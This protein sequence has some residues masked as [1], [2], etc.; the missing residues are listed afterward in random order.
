MSNALYIFIA[1]TP[2][3]AY[4]CWSEWTHH[5]LPNTWTMGMLAVALVWRWGYGGWHLLV[6][7][8]LAG[9]LGGLVLL[10]PFLLKAAGG[11]D[12]KMLTA[13][14]CVLGTRRLL[15]MLFIMSWLGLIMAVVM[16]CTQKLNRQYIKHYLL[17]LFYWGYDR[18]AGRK[19]LPPRLRKDAWAPFGLAIAGGA[20]A[21]LILD[22]ILGGMVS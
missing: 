16:L 21:T 5:L 12:L 11:G 3:L 19:M 20:W 18:A 10:L 7:G 17:C 8:L 4:L 9:V 13:V 6:D 22:L 14:C 15:A 2:P 1:I